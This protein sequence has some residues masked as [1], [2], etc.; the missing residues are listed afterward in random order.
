MRVLI[1]IKTLEI[2]I[3]TNK[4]HDA[5]ISSSRHGTC[6][7]LS[8]VWQVAEVLWFSMQITLYN[9]VNIPRDKIHL[10]EWSNEEIKTTTTFT[11]DFK[12]SL[13]TARTLSHVHILDMAILV[14]SFLDWV[15]LPTNSPPELVDYA[16]YSTLLFNVWFYDFCPPFFFLQR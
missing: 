13:A 2:T 4:R 9:R 12:W 8:I 16:K 6:I 3:W 11:D 14:N 1:W 5:F 15:A 7:G 10:I